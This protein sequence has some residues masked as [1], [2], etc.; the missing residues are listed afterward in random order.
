MYQVHIYVSCRYDESVYSAETSTETS[1]LKQTGKKKSAKQ[2]TGMDVHVQRRRQQPME[3]Q[4]V[5][6]ALSHP[7]TSKGAPHSSRG[8]LGSR[9]A[10]ASPSVAMAGFGGLLGTILR[11]T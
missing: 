6:K 1:Q 11:S 3:I 10:A 2:R 7:R 8:K 4:G 9:P 5:D